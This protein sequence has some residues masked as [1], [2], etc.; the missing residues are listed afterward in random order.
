MNRLTVISRAIKATASSGRLAFKSIQ[1]GFFLIASLIEKILDDSLTITEAIQILFTKGFQEDV[2]ASDTQGK[3]VIKPASDASAASDSNAKTVGKSISDSYAATDFIALVLSANRSFSDSSS[4][5]DLQALFASKSINDA[6]GVS[7]AAIISFVRLSSFSDSVEVVETV[8][9]SASP[10]AADSGSVGDSIS[11]VVQYH[12][13]VGDLAGTT[14]AVIFSAS[15][16]ISDASAVSDIAAM[17]VDRPAI[18]AGSVADTIA[19]STGLAKNDIIGTADAGYL[20][21][22]DY[23]SDPTYFADDYVGA[24]RTF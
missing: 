11:L 24:K 14:D 23:V 13:A 7:D 8:A 3:D 12:R 9:V 17:L 6:V 10:S 20:L 19:K 15:K 22:Q 18:D 1:S 2:G 5:T 21:N 4:T 16:A